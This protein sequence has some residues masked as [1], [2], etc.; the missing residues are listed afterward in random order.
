MHVGMVDRGGREAMSPQSFGRY[1]LTTE[2]RLGDQVSATN[3]LN[4]ANP[5]L[6]LGSWQNEAEDEPKGGKLG[7]TCCVGCCG[8]F[9][10]SRLYLGTI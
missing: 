8:M 6:E 7:V 3:V 10:R 1:I 9:H 5:V 2:K 4:N